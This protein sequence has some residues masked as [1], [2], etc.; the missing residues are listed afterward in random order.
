MWQMKH[1]EPGKQ[2]QIRDDSS[3]ES[4]TKVLIL[5]SLAQIVIYSHRT[6]K[7]KIK[8]KTDW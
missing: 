6:Q 1:Q 8:V 2:R 3:S 5:T 4:K 7:K